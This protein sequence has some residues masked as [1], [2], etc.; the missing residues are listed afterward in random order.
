MPPARVAVV[1]GGI[2]G[3]AAAWRLRR[4]AAASGR[5]LEVRL[6]EAAPRLGGKIATERRD[7]FLIEAGPDSFVTRKPEAVSLA[8]ELGLGGRLI[9]T[10]AAHNRVWMVRHGRLTEIPPA[11]GHV[12]PCRLAPIW[13]SDLLTWRGKARLALDLVLPRRRARGD[14]SLGAFLRRRFGREMVERLAGPLLAGIYVADPESLSLAATFPQ[15]AEIERRHGSVIR[16]MRAAGAHHAPAPAATRVSLAGGVGELVEALVAALGA[17]YDPAATDTPVHLRTACRVEHLERGTAGGW[18]LHLQDVSLNRPAGIGQVGEVG[19]VGTGNPGERNP[20]ERDRRADP[21]ERDPGERDP[22]EAADR[23]SADAVILALPAGGAAALLRPHVPAAAAA[24][25]AVRYVSTATVTLGYR[26]ADLPHPL[27]G[28]GFVVPAAE[29]RRITACTWSSAKFR[30]RAAPG[31][32]LLRVFL[33][34]PAAERRLES[35]DDAL[36]ADRPRRARRPDVADRPPD[37]HRRPPPPPRH[38]AVRGRPHRP[39][40]RHRSRPPPRPPPRRQRLPRHR[41]PRL[42]QERPK[43]RR[44]H[45]PRPPL[46]PHPDEGRG[47]P[48]LAKPQAVPPLRGSRRAPTRQDTSRPTPPRVAASASSPRHE[49]APSPLPSS[50]AGRG[51]SR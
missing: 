22:G 47:E 9:E 18:T 36:I 31:H 1:G 24:L 50:V 8:R 20:D 11:L 21:G 30:D 49:P 43:S 29:R 23:W 38:P 26:H 14:E 16:G 44:P 33:G 32:A 28:F 45:P 27:D 15:L 35:D 4:C 2:A 13:A 40:R 34:G 3:L 5:A 51:G 42:H 19:E 10:E 17:E 7:G 6:F 46:A 12:L 48:Q 25:A 41:H 37:P 39:H